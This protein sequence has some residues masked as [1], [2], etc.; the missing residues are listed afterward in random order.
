MLSALRLGMLSAMHKSHMG[1]TGI[2]NY[3]DWLEANYNI[4]E[5]KS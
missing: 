5:K 4:V 1:W 3:I 2:G